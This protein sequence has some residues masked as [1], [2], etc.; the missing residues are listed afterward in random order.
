MATRPCGFWLPVLIL[1]PSL[2]S[3]PLCSRHTALLAVPQ[4]VKQSPTSGCLSQLLLLLRTHFSQKSTCFRCLTKCHISV[5]LPWTLFKTATISFLSVT[6]LLSCVTFPTAYMYMHTYYMHPY[7]FV[8][9]AHHNTLSASTA[10]IFVCF[11]HCHLSSV[12][13]RMTNWHKAA[14]TMYFS[15]E[16]PCTMLGTRGIQNFTGIAPA[17][18]HWLLVPLGIWQLLIPHKVRFLRLVPQKLLCFS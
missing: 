6:I 16:L 18:R 11:V 1:T 17:L 15:G 12:T 7:A 5:S 13:P 2:T 8:V 3:H 10:E 4:H 9:G 14:P